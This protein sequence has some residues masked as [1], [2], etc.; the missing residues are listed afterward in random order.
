[1]KNPLRH[2][3]SLLLKIRFLLVVFLLGLGAAG[4]RAEVT[5]AA[6][7]VNGQTGYGI[8]PLTPVASDSDVTVVGLTRGPGVATSGSG[9][10]NVWGGVLSLIHI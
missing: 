10:S 6:W 3:P 9:A 2:F 4:A 8:S 7:E 1:M 5:L